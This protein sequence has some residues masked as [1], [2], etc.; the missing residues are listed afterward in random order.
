MMT[1]IMEDDVVVDDEYTVED[2]TLDDE[3]TDPLQCVEC[4]FVGKTAGGLKR[5]HTLK[6][7]DYQGPADT[8]PK[9]SGRKT[10][11][12]KDLGQLFMTL[13]LLGSMVNQYDGMVIANNAPQMA[14]AWAALAR[15][16]PQVEKV[17]RS[18][19]SGG[20]FGAV[21][22]TTLP[23]II[24][25]SANHGLLPEQVGAMVGAPIPVKSDDAA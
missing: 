19:M 5:H 21:V 10:D 20:A 16:N 4:D 1:D 13:A 2:F 7:T 6:H 3:V 11:L 18:L 24:A 25:I 15:Q 8:A 9:G 22:I 12:E 23:V 14:A 17:L